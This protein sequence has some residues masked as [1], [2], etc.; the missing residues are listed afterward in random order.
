MHIELSCI[1][2]NIVTFMDWPHSI[3]S[4]KVFAFNKMVDKRNYAFVIISN[5]PQVLL[6]ELNLYWTWNI[7]V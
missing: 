3:V 1:I 6:I 5:M 7:S 4:A 2:A